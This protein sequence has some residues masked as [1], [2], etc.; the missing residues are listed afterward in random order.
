MK[1]RLGIFVV[2]AAVAMAAWDATCVSG[3]GGD[4]GATAATQAGAGGGGDAVVIKAKN[5]EANDVPD[6]FPASYTLP[7]GEVLTA[8]N[9]QSPV[10]ADGKLSAMAGTHMTVTDNPDKTKVATFAWDEKGV[11]ATKRRVILTA[12]T[13]V[14]FNGKLGTIYDIDEAKS[15]GAVVAY[16]AKDGVYAVMLRF[17]HGLLQ[18]SA[19]DLQPKQVAG[20][21]S[22]APVPTAASNQSLEKRAAGIAAGLQLNDAGKE[23]AVYEAVLAQTRGVRDAHNAGFGPPKSLRGEFNTALAAV[24]TAD[25]IDKVKDALTGDKTPKTFAAYHQI[26]QDLNAAD[27]EV[28]LGLLKQAREDSL[29]VKNLEEMA[30]I[31]K[32]YKNQIETYL[33]GH[34]R[35]Y[36]ALYKKF[37][38]G[39]KG[40]GKADG[41]P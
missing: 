32:R 10:P 26:V 1:T 19:D 30:P 27:D 28:I 16:V 15:R 29:D 21:K 5:A 40:A 6:P 34:G 13:V 33:N 20:L 35:D 22:I 2:C 9:V 11:G 3:A 12:D 18:V 7:S 39:E 8:A 23:K 17:G 37:V 4:A 24:L 36:K 41:G 14:N 31:Y 25:Q 38:D